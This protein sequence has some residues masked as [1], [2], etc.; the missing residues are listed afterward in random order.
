MRFASVLFMIFSVILTYITTALEDSCSTLPAAKFPARLL[1]STD[2]SQ[3]INVAQLLELHET[4]DAE[5]RSLFTPGS[6]I[7]NVTSLP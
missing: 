1:S 6:V 2:F 3:G 5:E 4:T 7:D